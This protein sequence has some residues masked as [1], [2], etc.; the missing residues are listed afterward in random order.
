MSLQQPNPTPDEDNIRELHEKL[1]ALTRKMGLHLQQ[2]EISATPQ[3]APLP[4][5]LKGKTIATAL[6][7]VGDLAFSDEVQDPEKAKMKEE[8]RDIV[9]DISSTFLDIREQLRKESESGFFDDDT[10]AD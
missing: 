7:I 1:D 9:P 4:E 10:P 2:I 3:D 6:F 5:M 8:F